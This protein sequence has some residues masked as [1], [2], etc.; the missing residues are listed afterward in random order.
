MGE[1]KVLVAGARGMV[2]RALCRALSGKT[3]VLAPLRQEVD[4]TNTFSVKSYLERERPHTVI[5]AAAKVGGIFANATYPADFL[6]ENLMIASNLIHQSYL[7]EVPRL[8]F[9]G[10]TCIYPKFAEQPI[11][12]EALLT[13]SLESTNEAYALAKIAGV[14]LCE[15]YRKQYKCSYISAMPTN[16]YGPGDNYHLE[17]AHVLPALLRRFHEAKEEGKEEVMIWGTGQAKREFLHV[18]DLAQACLFLL[19]HYDE[20]LPVNIGS[21]EEVSILELAHQVAETVGFKGEIVT[22]PSKPDGTPRKKTNTSRMDRLGWKA[23]ISLKEGL[24][25]TY[26]DFLSK[27]P[28]RV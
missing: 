2:G 21:Q 28:L 6:Y 16:L 12:E 7:T 13:G 25:H 23:K 14:K 3:Q 18:D 1:T 4:Y 11:C 15:F 26:E 19:D 17:N 24:T 22:D 9:L 8:L 5:V 20:S 10:S 27:E